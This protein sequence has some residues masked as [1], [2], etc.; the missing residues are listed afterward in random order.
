MTIILALS[1]VYKLWKLKK[2]RNLPLTVF[3]ISSILTLIC[4]HK[5]I[6]FDSMFSLVPLLHGFSI[7]LRDVLV[8]G[9]VNFDSVHLRYHWLLFSNIKVKLIFAL[10][11]MSFSLKVI[12]PKDI[13]NP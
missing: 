13:L 12:F 1:N 7:S 3:Y 4:N 9:L 10:A 6:P 5:M 11:I 2:L 8:Y